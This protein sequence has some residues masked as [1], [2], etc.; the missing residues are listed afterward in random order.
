MAELTNKTA[1]GYR[2]RVEGLI[3]A[4][5]SSGRLV[6]STELR[7]GR[8]RFIELLSYLSYS[9]RR[10]IIGILAK[11][12]RQVIFFGLQTAAILCLVPKRY[13]KTSRITVDVCDSWAKLSQV[14]SKTNLP[15]S[16]LKRTLIRVIYRS[17]AK[18][19]KIFSFISGSDRAQDAHFI[20]GHPNLTIV[21]NGVPSWCANQFI[22]RK[23]DPNVLLFIGSGLYPPNREA[24]LNGIELLRDEMQSTSL[25]IR[26]VGEGW[27]HDNTGAVEYVGW[28]DDLAQEYE[29]AG[30]TLALL[31][32]GAGVSN[33]VVESLAVGRAVFASKM[34]FKQFGS[35]PGVHL[36][37][38]ET[39]GD[40]LNRLVHG[41][42]E[43]PKPNW[44]FPQWQDSVGG[45]VDDEK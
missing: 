30:A 35:I 9:N 39:V 3:S 29:S 7:S 37:N 1:P 43:T 44:V 31:D 15:K 41:S 23:G 10:R 5:I 2:I 8:L 12:Q 40:L 20:A 22:D 19:V 21:E 27:P 13:L 34:I 42:L 36:A 28:V 26:V 25:K 11:P 24:L 17:L 45:L 33:K 32:S 14:R 16:F 38:P 18:K 4:L 6:E